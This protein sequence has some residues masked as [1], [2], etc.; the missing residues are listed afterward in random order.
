MGAPFDWSLMAAERNDPFRFRH[1]FNEIACRHLSCDHAELLPADPGKVSSEQFSEESRKALLLAGTSGKPVIDSRPERLFLPLFDQA[2]LYGI[3]A[4]EGGD[5]DLYNKHTTRTLLDHGRAITADYLALSA[6][7]IDPLTGLFNSVIWREN[8]ESCLARRE[9]FVLVL[10]EIHPRARDAAHAHAYLQRAAGALNSIVGRGIP[11]FHFGAGVFGM[12]WHG[13]ASG[14]ARTLADVILYRLQRDGLDRVQMGQ[15]WVKGS[16]DIGFVKLMDRAWGAVVTARQRGPFAKAVYQ[17]AA[18][19]S[20][21]PFRSL[22]PPEMN[23]LRDLWRD[24]EKFAVAALKCDRDRPDLPELLEP[25]LGSGEHL[26]RRESGEVFIFLAGF[27]RTRVPAAIKELQDK[28]AGGNERTFSAG[29]ALFPCADF[30]RSE[31]PLN[32]R[33]ALQHTFFF[34]P[35]TVTEFNGVSLNISGDVYY[36]EGD[37]NGAVREYRRGLGLDPR[38]VNLLNS[39]GVAYV[40]LNRVKAAINCFEK[41]LGV[42][43][44]NYMALFNL[45]S[46]W[47]TCDRDDLAVGFLEKAL[48]VD[49]RIFDPV[50]QLAEL[51][52]RSGRYREVVELLDVDQVGRDRRA[53]WEDA[54]ALRC[55]GEAW[56]HLGENRRAMECLQQANVFN[57]RD[58]RVLSLLGELYDVEGQGGDIALSLCREAVELDDARWDNLYRLGLVL[59]RQGDRQGA[60]VN[61]QKSLRLK[62]SNLDGARLLEKIYRKTGKERLAVRIAEKVGKISKKA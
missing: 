61:L 8:L 19:R 57:P 9:D 52:C 36:N 51:Y 54:A 48:A 10:L 32:A 6:R 3:A 16:D 1:F 41:A 22:S 7:A 58:S 45:G 46:A 56:R 43:G 49:D 24:E 29:F 34:G 25:H 21:H 11:L 59:Y 55:L 38:N 12:V 42:E 39:L 23:R 18:E 14:E 17:S 47:L 20:R 2:T 13:L 26:I 4:V 30:K 5:P 40:R 37:M 31:V 50:L 28:V 53:D 35:G 44:D 33:K 27:D 60:V 62:R 15:V